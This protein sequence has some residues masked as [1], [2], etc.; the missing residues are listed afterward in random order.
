MFFNGHRTCSI[1]FG[2]RFVGFRM[3]S[4]GSFENQ[5]PAVFHEFHCSGRQDLTCK[6][7]SVAHY[8]GVGDVTAAEA[9]CRVLGVQMTYTVLQ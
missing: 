8:H 5:I 9:S 4:V 1:G 7:P 6:D 3:F 2:M